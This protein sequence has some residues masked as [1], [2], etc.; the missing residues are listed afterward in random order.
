[1]ND[2]SGRKIWNNIVAELLIH[3]SQWSKYNTPLDGHNNNKIENVRKCQSE[4]ME[5][6]LQK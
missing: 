4:N 2:R 5:M 3:R 6:D 1:M